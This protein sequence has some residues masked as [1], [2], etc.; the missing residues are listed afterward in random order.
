MNAY[1]R[2]LLAEGAHRVNRELAAA[3]ERDEAARRC[4]SCPVLAACYDHG[5]RNGEVGVW[6]GVDLGMTKRPRPNHEGDTA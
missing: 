2:H 3:A 1:N 6:G 4:T 5:R